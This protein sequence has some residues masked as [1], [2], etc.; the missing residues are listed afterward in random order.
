MFSCFFFFVLFLPPSFFLPFISSGTCWG[1]YWLSRSKSKRTS[2][3]WRRSWPRGWRVRRPGSALSSPSRRSLHLPPRLPLPARGLCQRWASPGCARPGWR[4]CKRPAITA[5]STATWTSPWS[6]ELW[7][8]IRQQEEEELTFGIML[9]LE[10]EKQTP[11]LSFSPGVP[12]KLHVWLESLRCAQQQSRAGVTLSLLRE[13]TTTIREEDYCEE[14]VAVGLP[15]MFNILRTTKVQT[16]TQ[17]HQ[18]F[19]SHKL[20]SFNIIPF[21]PV[22]FLPEWFHYPAASGYF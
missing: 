12:W 17:Y 20:L 9:T 8:T 6:Y 7:V 10:L 21:S 16:Q 4:L 15:L 2:C 14:L 5:P 11:P 22:H 18:A 3:L 13:F 19:N 1:S